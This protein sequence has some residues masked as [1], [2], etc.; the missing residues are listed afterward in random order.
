MK[1]VSIMP[2]GWKIGGITCSDTGVT[3]SWR[4]EI[5]RIAMIDKALRESNINFAMRS[6]SQDGKTVIA[7]TYYRIPTMK[8]PPVYS[9]VETVNIINDLFQLL[10]VNVNVS[11]EEISTEKKSKQNFYQQEDVQKYKVVKFT[12]QS[13]QNPLIWLEILTKFSGLQISMI[14][15]NAESGIWNYEGAIYVL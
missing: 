2:P 7:S 13:Q 9:A 15:Y 10:S 5:G 11:E 8:S 3:T 6:I 4:L 1:M 12:F 14:K